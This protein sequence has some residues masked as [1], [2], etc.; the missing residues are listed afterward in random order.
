MSSAN[1]TLL[2]Q[3]IWESAVRQYREGKR[4][5]ANY[6]SAEER[7]WLD[8]LGLT[9]QEV[10]D[11][12]EDFAQGGEPDWPA[13]QAIHEVRKEY[14]D[15][16]QKGR[17]STAQLDPATLPAKDAQVRG[18]RWLPRLIPK[19]KA[20]L[21][22]ELHPDIMYSCGGDRRFLREHGIPAAE[23][24]RVVWQNENDDHAVVEWVT[25]RQ[26]APAAAQ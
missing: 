7:G 20:K 13:F 1:D 19:A 4:G 25:R 5:S 11:F 10:Y 26:K 17:R 18:I 6:F 9:V 24:L 2:L 23:F 14:F 3:K 15:T 22:G 12:A 21:R 8:T 16:V